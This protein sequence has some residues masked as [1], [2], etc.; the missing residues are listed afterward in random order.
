LIDET[1]NHYH[2][3][4]VVSTTRPETMGI[5]SCSNQKINVMKLCRTICTAASYEKKNS[6]YRHYVDMDFGAGAK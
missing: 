1:R 3:F 6:R 5:P 2:E 4:I